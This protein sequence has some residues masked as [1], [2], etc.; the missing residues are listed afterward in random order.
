M[1][2]FALGAVALVAVTLSFALVALTPVR[3]TGNGASTERPHASHA[4]H[5][6]AGGAPETMARVLG[7]L[8]RL[9]ALKERGALTAKEFDAQKTKLLKV[10]QGPEPAELPRR[11]VS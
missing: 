8:E 2:A 6:D 9:A 5:D 4:S 3:T 7:E 1:T 10:S 11:R